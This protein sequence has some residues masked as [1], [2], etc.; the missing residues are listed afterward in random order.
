M[1][2]AGDHYYNEQGNKLNQINSINIYY[3][4]HSLYPTTVR[5]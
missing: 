1:Y 5:K 3:T 4:T 2:S